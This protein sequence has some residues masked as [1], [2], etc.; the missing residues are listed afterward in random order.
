[1]PHTFLYL[2]IVLVL[3]MDKY[4]RVCSFYPNTYNLIINLKYCA[5]ETP[6]ETNEEHWER[7]HFPSESSRKKLNV[8]GESAE[9]MGFLMLHTTATTKNSYQVGSRT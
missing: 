3:Y 6:F 2:R 5:R 1:M 7:K 9:D 8:S 4:M